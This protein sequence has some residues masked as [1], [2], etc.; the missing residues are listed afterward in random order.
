LKFYLE[1]AKLRFDDIDCISDG[2]RPSFDDESPFDT[3]WDND[4]V[5]VSKILNRAFLP[6]LEMQEIWDKIT[7][8]DITPEL[9]QQILNALPPNFS[10]VREFMVDA[11]FECIAQG[12][13]IE[14]YEKYLTEK[15]EK[16]SRFEQMR[17][18]A[19]M[20]KD[21]GLSP[22]ENEEDENN[23]NDESFFHKHNKNT[24]K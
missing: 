7:P 1:E 21:S 17:L 11:M 3:D 10:I 12:I 9:K 24:K 13:S 19:S 22:N 4:D 18:I 8:E 15:V 23:N 20:F 5:D 14:Q 16:L 2:F 6:S